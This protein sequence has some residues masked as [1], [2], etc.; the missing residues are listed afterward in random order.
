MSSSPALR[1]HTLAHEVSWLPADCP[2]LSQI[3]SSSPSHPANSFYY[4]RLKALPPIARVTLVRVR[5]SPRAYVPPATDLASRG[6]EILDSLPGK[7]RSLWCPAAGPA[8]AR[9][10]ASSCPAPS[11]LRALP[12]WCHTPRDMAPSLHGV[13]DP[14]WLPGG[15]CLGH[16]GG[17][18]RVHGGLCPPALNPILTAALLPKVRVRQ[19][20]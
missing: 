14:F 17:R 11:A 6:N 9:C 7:P 2:S 13:P 15:T 19:M 20:G 12:G 4:P 5:Q 16:V 8:P 1:P 3:T 18:S 10:G